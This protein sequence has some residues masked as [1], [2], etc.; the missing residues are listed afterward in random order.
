MSTV[1]MLCCCN[2]G[3]VFV[4]DRQTCLVL[5]SST[6]VITADPLTVKVV[7]F[8]LKQYASVPELQLSSFPGSL[9]CG[10]IEHSRHQL[11]MLLLAINYILY[12]ELHSISSKKTVTL[13]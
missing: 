2:V 10:N 3:P 1:G 13:G 8:D 12:V 11:G 5:P 4:T 6:C 7:L 9:F